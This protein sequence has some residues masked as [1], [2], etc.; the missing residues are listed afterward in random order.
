VLEDRPSALSLNREDQQRFEAMPWL[1]QVS[2]LAST[3][4]ARGQMELMQERLPAETGPR[5]AAA[6]RAIWHAIA[7]WQEFSL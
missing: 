7:N 3:I 6:R 1:L 5:G 2:S 4:L